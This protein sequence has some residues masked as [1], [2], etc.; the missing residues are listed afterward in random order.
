MVVNYKVGGVGKVDWTK[1]WDKYLFLSSL[2]EEEVVKRMP[3]IETKIMA[4]PTSLDLFFKNE[5]DYSFP[6]RLIRHNSQGDNKHHVDTDNMMNNIISLVPGVEF[7]SMPGFSRCM[8]HPQVF[9]YEKNKP[10]VWDF[11]KRGNC[12]FYRLPDGYTEGGPKV[13]MEAMAS[14]LPV[15]ADNHSG[16]KDRVTPETGWLCNSW[17]D[18]IKAIMDIVRNPELLRIKGEAAREYAKEHFIAE[19]WIEEILE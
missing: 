16:P 8:Q 5:I 4:P 3:G 19:R 17:S 11:L 7:H 9:N 2:L 13:I 14:G 18:Y 6:L 15:I 12:F 10:F 1:G